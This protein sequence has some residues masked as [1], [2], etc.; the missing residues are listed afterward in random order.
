[1]H[2]PRLNRFNLLLS[3][4]AFGLVAPALQAEPTVDKAAVPEFSPAVAFVSVATGKIHAATVTQANLNY[5]GSIT[6]DADLLDAAGFLPHMLVQITNNSTG[7]FWETYII[8][9]TRGSGIISLNG[10]PARHFAPGDKVFIV[11]HALVEP[12]KLKE[13]WMRTV[14]VDENNKIT[15]VQKQGYSGDAKLR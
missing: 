4:V 5:M 2:N 13:H 1:M 7:A 11:S 12:A 14:F 3:I 9:G 6:I 15:E 10:A 8:E